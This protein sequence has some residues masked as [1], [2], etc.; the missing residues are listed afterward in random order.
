MPL[1]RRVLQGIGRKRIVPV[2]TDHRLASLAAHVHHDI[3]VRSLSD[4]VTEAHDAHNSAPSDV[5]QRRLERRDVPVDVRNYC[6][7]V[8][9]RAFTELF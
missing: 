6:N 5:T 4:Q 8:Q 7:L 2:A 3:G 9:R 1:D